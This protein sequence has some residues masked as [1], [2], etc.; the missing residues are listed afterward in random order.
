MACRVSDGAHDAHAAHNACFSA[1]AHTADAD[2]VAMAQLVAGDRVV[3]LDAASGAPTIDRVVFNQH[4]PGDEWTVLLRIETANG[5]ALTVTPDH[6]IALNGR[7]ARASA[8]RNGS[9]LS[10]SSVVRVTTT[11]GG[12]INPVTTSGTILAAD[13][14]APHVPLLASTHPE[15]VA[16]LFLSA[17]TFPLVATR[18]ASYLAP[19]AAQACY[20]AIEP[21]LAYVAPTAQRAVA[22]VPVA[23]VLGLIA[24]DVAFVLA[25]AASALVVPLGAAY[26]ASTLVQAKRR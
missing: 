23:A 1:D 25:F 24:F 11:M 3:T 8:A 7:F 26:A 18:L 13:K 10:T 9:A 20:T 4:L 22:A 21:A 2:L 15:W 6:T 12:I 19:K 14:D 5:G 16:E 17:P